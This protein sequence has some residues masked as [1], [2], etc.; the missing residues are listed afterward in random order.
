[1]FR[2]AQHLG[3]IVSIN[4]PESPTGEICMGCG[5]TPT[6]SVDMNL[7]TSVEV[8]NGGGQPA[9]KFWEQEL[10]QG[11]R[12]TAIGGSDNHHADW[13]PEKPGS[14]GYPTTVVYAPSLSV[15]GI[16]NGI[17]SGRVFI[18]VTGSR[19]RLLEMSAKDGTTSAEMGGALE[20][21]SGESV[22]LSI[23]VKACEGASVHFFLDGAPSPDLPALSVS[24]ADQTLHADWHADG[25]RHFIRVE[26]HDA[27]G[28]LL[29]LGNP[30]YLGFPSPSTH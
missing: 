3:A 14:I 15:A 11:H 29:L 4:H 16:L 20:P 30:V 10:R 23:H 13:P 17:R 8:V 2:S 22:S 27:G 25:A 28:K 26:V 24:S 19:D 9:T 5:W 21:R 18:D 7:V 12:L 6:T 1:M